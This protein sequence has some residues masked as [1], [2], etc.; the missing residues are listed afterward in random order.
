MGLNIGPG[1]SLLLW[2]LPM[3]LRSVI[4]TSTDKDGFVR[5]LLI[6]AAK[7]QLVQFFIIAIKRGQVCILQS[8]RNCHPPP[9]FLKTADWQAKMACNE[10]WKNDEM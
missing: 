1:R 9:S 6:T 2:V 10:F 8:S 5:D 4:L 3:R 7:V